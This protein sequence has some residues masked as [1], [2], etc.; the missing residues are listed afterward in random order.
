MKTWTTSN[1]DEI[2][3]KD[4]E[5]SHILN[6]K[7]FIEKKANEGLEMESGIDIDSYDTYTMSGDEV[8][9]FFDYDGI[10]KEIKRRKLK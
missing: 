8:F 9:D 2:K 10:I 5:D 4:L 7:L 3:Y 6:I 1:G